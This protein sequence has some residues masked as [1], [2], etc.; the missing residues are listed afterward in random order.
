MYINAQIRKYGKFVG[1]IAV[2]MGTASIIIAFIGYKSGSDIY[3][4]GNDSSELHTW[5]GVEIGK[6]VSGLFML[7]VG[8]V[9][10]IAFRKI[11][12]TKDS[13][14]ESLKVSA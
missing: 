5:N 7:I 1:W 10:I 2:I 12:K 13:P 3:L 9:H 14:N 4:I 6:V 11:P 8:V